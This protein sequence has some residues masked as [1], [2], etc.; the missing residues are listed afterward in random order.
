[1]CWPC[2]TEGFPS[3][4]V[5][6]AEDNKEH[7]ELHHQLQLKTVHDARTVETEDTRSVSVRALFCLLTSVSVGSVVSLDAWQADA[8]TV[9]NKGQ[10]NVNQDADFSERLRILLK[11]LPGLGSA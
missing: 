2:S 3:E 1:M 5:V 6:P 4:G 11:I 8:Q 7:A 10:P 9:L